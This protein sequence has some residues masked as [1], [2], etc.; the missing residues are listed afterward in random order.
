MG[1]FLIRDLRQGCNTEKYLVSSWMLYSK[2]MV[3]G[4]ELGINV[5]YSCT[6][7][8]RTTSLQYSDTAPF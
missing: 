2:H 8:P 5:C 1:R 6:R 3:L 7:H 4:Y